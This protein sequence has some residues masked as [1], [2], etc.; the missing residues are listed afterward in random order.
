MPGATP[1][2]GW[3]YPIGTDRL[4]EAVTT[5]PEELALAIETTLQVWGGIAAPGSFTTLTPAAGA[6]S[7]APF[8]N[9]GY[10]KIGSYVEGRGRFVFAAGAAAGTTL[11]TFPVGFRPVATVQLLLAGNPSYRTELT[12]AGVFKNID[13][14]GAGGT[15]SIDGL[16]YPVD[17]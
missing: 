4:D 17:A 16:R 2:Y 15:L 9:L 14:I 3:P 5:I 8:R 10:R 7:G 13:A 6:N 1:V 12:S 11:F